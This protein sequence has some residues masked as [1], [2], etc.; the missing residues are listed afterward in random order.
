[1]F[2]FNI[3]KKKLDGQ[4]ASVIYPFHAGFSIVLS[5]NKYSKAENKGKDRCDLV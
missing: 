1:V 2:A 4:L 3:Q 5:N